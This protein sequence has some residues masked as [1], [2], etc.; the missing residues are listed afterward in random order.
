MPSPTFPQMCTCAHADLYYIHHRETSLPLCMSS[1]LMRG[2][3]RQ[4]QD[5]ACGLR[6]QVGGR[7]FVKQAQGLG[8]K[9]LS[10]PQSS[11]SWGQVELPHSDP[12][13]HKMLG[14][15]GPRDGSWPWWFSLLRAE[16]PLFFQK[17]LSCSQDFYNR[18]CC[19]VSNQSYP[20]AVFSSAAHFL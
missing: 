13:S 7:A 3:S 12:V 8:F 1:V 5:N 17:C 4:H 20:D 11:Q 2:V 6:L 15:T 16:M 14:M 9:S 18:P 19:S 10:R